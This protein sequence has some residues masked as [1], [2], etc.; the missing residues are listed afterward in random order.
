MARLVSSSRDERD[1]GF[2]QATG[3]ARRA[4][5]S[6]RLRLRLPHLT[7]DPLVLEPDPVHEVDVVDELRKARDGDEDGQHVWRLGHVHRT[8]ALLEHLHDTPVLG[9]ET[10]ESGRLDPKL[11]AQLEQTRPLR[12]ELSVE[13]VEVALR[14]V[15]RRLRRP[16]RARD[17]RELRREDP[18][19]LLRRADL[20]L[21]RR[22][23]RVDPGL[24]T[25]DAVTRR[26]RGDREPEGHGGDEQPASPH[27]DKVRVR[28]GC[29]C[30]PPSAG[31]CS[32]GSRSSACK[33]CAASRRSGPTS[34]R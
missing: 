14:L 30:P 15:H 28:G 3:L 27:R 26:G 17:L 16:Q 22:D 4:A 10:G 11:R 12:G 5:L 31:G 24:P 23:A 25:P 19:A 13:A 6:G 20:V 8:H 18:F 29:P 9:L 2:R 1:G 34:R 21:E 33:A 32:A 7:S